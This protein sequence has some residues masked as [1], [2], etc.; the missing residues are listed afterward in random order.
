MFTRLFPPSLSRLT[1]AVLLAALSLSLFVPLVSGLLTALAGWLA[2]LAQIAT[3]LFVISAGL[4]GSRLLLTLAAWC[5]TRPA[6]ATGRPDVG[7]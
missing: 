4:L 2:L 7:P 6:A 5:A 1:K 3:C